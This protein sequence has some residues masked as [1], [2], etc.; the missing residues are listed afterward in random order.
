MPSRPG[1]RVP[2]TARLPSSFVSSAVSLRSRGAAWV[3]AASAVLGL[4]LVAVLVITS[5]A[6]PYVA[7]GNAD[8]GGLVRAGTP[9]LRFVV[10]LSAALCTGSLVF[11]ACFTQPRG[12]GELAPAAYA[13]VRW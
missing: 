3:L 9:L 13:A 12:R 1:R 2:G 10:D 8:P 4:A 11:A 5:G 6:A 7:L